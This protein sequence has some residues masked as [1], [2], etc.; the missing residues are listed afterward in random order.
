MDINSILEV[1][2]VLITIMISCAFFLVR[3]LCKPVQIQLGKMSGNVDCIEKRRQVRH[4]IEE[5]LI[6]KDREGIFK[7]GN[8]FVM[9]TSDVSEGGLK[10]VGNV[11]VPQGT[12]LSIRV[13]RGEKCITLEGRVVWTRKLGLLTYLGGVEF[14]Q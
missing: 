10:F 1:Q 13:N 12:L 5:A 2:F 3:Q 11:G 4:Y 8:Q 14:R 7:H 6:C 9:T